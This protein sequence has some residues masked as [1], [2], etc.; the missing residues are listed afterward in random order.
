VV[1]AVSVHTDVNVPYDTLTPYTYQSLIDKIEAGDSAIGKAYFIL[2]VSSPVASTNSQVT[3]SLMD[4]AGTMYASGNAYDYSFTS[5]T[6]QM[7]IEA[8][9]VISVPS[10]VPPSQ[11]NQRY[12][13]RWTL[14]SLDGS[15]PDQYQFENISVIGLTTTPEGPQDTV[16][17]SGD[18]AHVSVVLREPY[19]NVTYEVFSGN[20]RV[21]TSPVVVNLRN[22]V[23]T[24]WYYEAQI[25]TSDATI[26]TPGLDPFTVSWRYFNMATPWQINRSTSRM[27]VVTPSVM[28][29]IEDVKSMVS[30]AQTTLFQF[31]D[32]FF[33]PEVILSHMRTGRDDFNAAAGVLTNFTMTF[34]TGAIRSFWLAYTYVSILR[35]QYI[36]EGEKA[37]N[38][39][40]DAISLEVD[41]TQYY[42]GLANEILQ[43]VQNDVKPFKTNL[44]K[45]GISGGDGDMNKVPAAGSVAAL[46]VSMTPAS[47]WARG[48]WPLWNNM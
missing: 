46:G 8:N 28:T 23:S 11:D 41:R 37:F 34:A 24:G 32:M 22:R 1:L 7:I 45:K 4:V 18:P 30:R 38:F 25:D 42:Q 2:P 5:D 35:S 16:E 29:A 19:T 27:F 9:A 26:Y 43:Q 21:T 40:G 12:Q 48:V 3:W 31:P 39:T 44:I 14:T 17:L 33:S 15:F 36:A 10:T 20:T 47:Q 13:V 6:F